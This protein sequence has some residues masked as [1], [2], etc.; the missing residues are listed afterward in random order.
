MSALFRIGLVHG[1][2]MN[3]SG[4]INYI[5][6]IARALSVV[7]AHIRRRFEIHLIVTASADVSHYDCIR[8]LFRAVH[9]EEDYI[10]WLD[11]PAEE[12]AEAWPPLHRFLRDLGLDFVYPYPIH[13]PIPAAPDI[14]TA[15]WIPDFQHIHLPE[16]FSDDEIRGRTGH[17]GLIAHRLDNVVLSSESAFSD[18]RSLFP[19]AAE[20]VKVLRFRTLAEASWYAGDAASVVSAYKLP[21]RYF[22]VCNQFWQHKNH[23]VVLD[24]LS[25]LREEGVFPEIVM[26]GGLSDY[27]NPVY[28]D[29][30]LAKIH[31]RGLAK[32]VYLLGM[33]PRDRQ[34]QL[35]RA[36]QAVIQPS[37]FEGW[38]TI[39]E[40]S[41]AFGKLLLMSDI[42]VHLEQA[43][44]GGRYFERHSASSLAKLIRQSWNTAT[45]QP[46]PAQEARARD[47][48][49]AEVVEFG[50]HFLKI[51][52]LDI[53]TASP[54]LAATDGGR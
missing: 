29:S 9:S 5:Q 40:D 52:G 12:P 42:D 6:N 39:V 37:L 3:W 38:S 4:G 26:T 36:A 34:I 17:F 49:L 54:R 47:S 8:H 44:K 7:P 50:L 31:Q 28:I 15:A 35:L 2:A 32:Q 45:P 10:G 51:A 30:I 14:N 20:K 21:A 25:L 46:D 23:H 53:G 16:F 11:K 1:P 22:I 43:P 19:E 18:F 13:L 48:N 24:A 33:L 41:R 27:R